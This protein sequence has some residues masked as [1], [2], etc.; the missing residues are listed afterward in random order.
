MSKWKNGLEIAT[1]VAILC[2]CILI[3]AIAIRRFLLVDPLGS[4]PSVPPPG[5]Q[6]SLPGVEWSRANRTLLMVLSTQCHFCSESADFYR[7]LLPEARARNIPVV[8]AFAQSPEEARQYLGNLGL[9]LSSI[10]VTQTPPAVLQ[11][12]GTPT[13]MVVDGKGLVIRAW[14]GKLPAQ[15]EGEVF[16]EINSSGGNHD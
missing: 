5:T 11:V 7:R 14:A 9:P 1:N 4:A 8:A 15:T 2:V 10:A 3:G 13:V 16:M 12:P 6:L